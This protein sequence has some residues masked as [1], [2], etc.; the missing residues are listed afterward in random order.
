MKKNNVFKVIV[1]H[2]CQVIPALRSHSFEPE[3]RLKDLGAN[4][5]DRG[6]IID[7]VMESLALECPRVELFG[8]ETIGE[9]VEKIHEKLGQ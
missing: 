3:D 6:E 9:L 1:E 2:C 7:L 5:L 4:S 8:A